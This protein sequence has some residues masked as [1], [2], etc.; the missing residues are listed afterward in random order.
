MQ[1]EINSEL[2]RRN[3]GPTSYVG[4]ARRTVSHWWSSSP[5]TRQALGAKS[6]R[7]A[8]F[9]GLLRVPEKTAAVVVS[10]EMKN[11]SSASVKL[12]VAE[13]KALADRK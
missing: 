1:R 3:P 6:V 7:E 13:F 4:A 12:P 2:R 9:R 8:P 11:G 5:W 10:I